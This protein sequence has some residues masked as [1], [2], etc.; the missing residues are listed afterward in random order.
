[1]APVPA[2]A[3]AVPAAAPFGVR[4]LDAAAEAFV[5]VVV[6]A[7]V[8]SIPPVAVVFSSGDRVR[9]DG[10]EAWSAADEDDDDEEDGTAVESAEDVAAKAAALAG[11][12]CAP[13][14]RRFFGS[15]AV[16]SAAPT[17]AA[18]VAALGRGANS[19]AVAPVDEAESRTLFV[20]AELLP[21]VPVDGPSKLRIS[22]PSL[23]ASAAL[24][25][26]TAD[27]LFP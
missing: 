25:D 27:W 17:A 6:V 1:M 5:D 2:L 13:S 3:A 20:L 8:V 14:T 22:P 4:P 15:G 11:G 24:T 12:L 19:T 7:V 16:A 18:A 9:L 23:A 21:S 10:G 26:V